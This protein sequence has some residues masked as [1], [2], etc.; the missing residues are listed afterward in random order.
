MTIIINTTPHAIHELKSNQTFEPNNTAQVRVTDTFVDTGETIEDVPILTRTFGDVENL[1][2]QRPN[3]F[4]IVSL[5]VKQA[6]PNRS[7]LFTPGKLVR[8]E[9]GVIVGCEGFIR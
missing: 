4:Y 9:N 7:D 6:L 8:N 5:V 3:V 2:A 1:P